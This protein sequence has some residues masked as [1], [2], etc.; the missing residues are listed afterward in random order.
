MKIRLVWTP[1]NR[2]VVKA[3]AYLAAALVMGAVLYGAE[4]AFCGLLV[5]LGRVVGVG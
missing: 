3:F 1:L 4:Y 5:W 2:F